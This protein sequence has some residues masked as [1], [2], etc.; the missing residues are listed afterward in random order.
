MNRQQRRAAARAKPV[1]SATPPNAAASV[2]AAAVR[3]HSAGRLA[4][5]EI[6][7]RRALEAN[8]NHAPALGSWRPLSFQNKGDVR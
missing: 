3:H 2:F 1:A 4:E 7:Y 5:A 8:P 6:Q